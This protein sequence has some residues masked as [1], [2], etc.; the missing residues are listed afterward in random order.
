M[1]R[2]RWIWVPGEA[3]RGLR[4]T[5]LALVLAT[6]WLA[7]C[8]GGPPEVAVDDPELVSG[9]NIYARNCASCHG[10][11]G[12]GGVGPKLSEGAVVVAY[13]NIEDQID[14][15]SN[16]RGRMPGYMGRLSGEEMQAV[17]RYTREI[18]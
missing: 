16:G 14:L 11:S 5:F 18:L 2:N 7:A 4:P 8:S 15:I 10:S 6:V 9:R 13:P 12:G 1:A 3:G 17:A